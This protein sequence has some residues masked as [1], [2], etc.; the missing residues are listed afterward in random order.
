M[1]LLKSLNQQTA[2]KTVY[3]VTLFAVLV[4]LGL[5]VAAPLLLEKHYASPALLLYQSFSA[6][7]HQRP[8]RSFHLSGF[9]LTV[10]ARC[11]GIYAGFLLGLLVYPFARRLDD[12]TMPER[13]WLL[14]AAAPMLIDVAGDAVGLFASSF[15]S[16]AITGLI[17]GA[18]TAFYL[19]PGLVATQAQFCHAR[20]R[21][22]HSPLNRN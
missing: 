5:I 15:A 13:R 18:A 21:L 7:C 6:I 1:K 12:E 20:L 17:G 9:P 14:L 19:F 10:C 11:A 22:N 2:A 4:W 3:A 16:R 8:E